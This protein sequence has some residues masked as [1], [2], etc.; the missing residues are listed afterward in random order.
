[1]RM[2]P[3]AVEDVTP[4]D[5]KQRFSDQ[6][7][8]YREA[9]QQSKIIGWR[10][11]VH[12]QSTAFDFGSEQQREFYGLRPHMPFEDFRRLIH[13]DD[14]AAT[15]VAIEDLIGNESPRYDAYYRMRIPNGEWR[16]IHSQGRTI[17]R[18][19]DGS[20]MAAHGFMQDVTDLKNLGE[21]LAIEDVF[22]RVS[23]AQT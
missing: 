17:V 4:V 9:L 20:S 19:A 13:P 22:A 15:I 2:P 16:L 14:L 5:W 1:M 21:A 3:A 10:A 8:L 12:D 7:A 18:A 11:D 6:Q 23:S